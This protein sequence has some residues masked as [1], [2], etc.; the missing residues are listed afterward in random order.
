MAKIPKFSDLASNVPGVFDKMKSFVDTLAGSGKT[1]AT[2]EALLNETEPVRIK[3]LEV[4]LLINQFQ[5]ILNQHQQLLSLLKNQFAEL[6]KMV[7]EKIP[8][9]IEDETKKENE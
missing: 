3:L 2:E 1:A 7:D 8:R 5:D 4:E 9:P 6:N